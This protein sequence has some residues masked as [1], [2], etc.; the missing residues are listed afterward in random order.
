[1]Q[2]VLLRRGQAVEEAFCLGE[3]A[4]RGGG[5]DAMVADLEETG[6][7]AGFADGLADGPAG[8]GRAIEGRA[9]VD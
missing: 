5:G 6:R 1:M 7:E 4:G 8:V 9:E 2:L 3:N